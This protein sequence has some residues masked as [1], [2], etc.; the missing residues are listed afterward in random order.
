MAVPTAVFSQEQDLQLSLWF[1]GEKTDFDFLWK[2]FG[3]L[4]N[5]NQ[6]GLQFPP[7]SSQA[8]V[9]SEGQLSGFPSVH[10]LFF[11][12]FPSIPLSLSVCLSP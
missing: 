8:M 6:I 4:W 7:C 12:S 2:S 5:Q 9:A 11:F 3:H 10:I 1:L